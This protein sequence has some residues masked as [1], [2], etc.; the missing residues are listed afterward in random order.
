M[1]IQKTR[2]AVL[3]GGDP[4]SFSTSLDSGKVIL[5]ALAQNEDAYEALDI[6]ISKDGLWHYRGLPVEPHTALKHA[7][8]AFS[9]LPENIGALQTLEHMH[10]PHVGS[11]IV[12]SAML[13]SLHH[14]R[15]VYARAGIPTLKFEILE[16]EKFNDKDLLQIFRNFVLPATVRSSERNSA[17]ATRAV[18]SFHELESAVKEAFKHT[19]KVIVEEYIKGKT[20]VSSVIENARNERLHALLPSE[21]KGERFSAPGSF[22]TEEKRAIEDLSRNAHKALGLRHFSSSKFIVTPK[23]KIYITETNTFPEMRDNSALRTSLKATGWKEKEFVEHL[24]NLA[25]NS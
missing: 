11:D 15:Q 13:G 23:G 20:A 25:R 22:S 1:P 5:S 9:T 24:L 6:F 4:S 21:I 19:K 8:I 14:M 10:V 3:R 2:V 12:P 18:T 17:F 16:E 7:D